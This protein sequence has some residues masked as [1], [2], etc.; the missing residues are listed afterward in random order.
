[1]IDSF[2]IFNELPRGIRR[3]VFKALPKGLPG[4]LQWTPRWIPKL[5]MPPCLTSLHQHLHLKSQ[6][7]L[8]ILAT[9]E[10]IITLEILIP[11]LITL[12]GILTPIQIL[13][14]LLLLNN[15][16]RNSTT[17]MSLIYIISSFLILNEIKQSD[18]MKLDK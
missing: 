4:Y 7:I 1:M 5:S 9:H 2:L 15:Q 10:Q 8:L 16:L 6:I 3:G 14:L 12:L 17:E 11:I 18:W 13:H